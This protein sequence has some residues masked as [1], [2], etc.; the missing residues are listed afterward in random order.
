MAPDVVYENVPLPAMHGIDEAAK[1]LTP[2]L[3]K[4]IKIEF[5]LLEPRSV[6]VRQ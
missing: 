2:L 6:G 1:F 4:T 5:K 3:T